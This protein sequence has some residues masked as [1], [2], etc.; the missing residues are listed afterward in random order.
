MKKKRGVIVLALTMIITAFLCY[1]AAV[2]L[3]PTGTGSAKNIHTG[4]DLSGGVSIT[5]QAK[6]KNP[7]KEEMSDTVYKMQKRVEQY[8]TEAQAYQE[9]DNRITVEIPGVTDAD[10]IL[11]DLGKPGSLCFIEQTDKDG[12]EN[13][14]PGEDNYVLARSLEEIREAGSVVLEG[15]DVADAQGGAYQK[16]DGSSR[17]YVVSLKLTDEGKKKFAEAT[18]ANVGKQI[19]IIYDNS[20]LSAPTV[21]EAITGG[22]AEINGMEDVEEAQN[23]A[24]YIRIGSLSLELEEL[25]SSVVAAQL[26]E[27]AISTSVT[28]G[29]IGLAIVILFMIFVYR[30][31]GLVAAIALILYTAITLITLNAFDI[32]LT[33]PGI[34]GIILGIGMAVDA[35]VIIY[36]RIQEEIAEGSSV[37]TAIKSG[38]SKAFSAIVDGN[39]TTLIASGVLMGLGSGT[40][41][42]FA[43]TL[44]LGIVVSMFT[45]LV[46]SRLVMNAMYA[47][48]IQ[49]EKFY[50]RAKKRKSINF[51]GKKSIFF[52]ISLVLIL[53]GPVSMMIHQK[54]DGSI[55]NYSLEFSG[56]TATTVTFNE[57]MDIKKIDSEVTPVVEK[58]TG[59]K[60][61]QPTKVVGTNQVVIKT[62]ALSQDEREALNTA[63]VEKFDVD[64]TLIT[65][66]SISS[67]VSSEMRQDAFVAV[68]V[69]TLCMLAY[70]W[71]RFKDI[72]F[73][74]SAVLALVHDVLVVFA[75]YALARV[76]V[77]N[78]FIACM[79]TIVGY[80]INATIVIFD[81]IREN[82]K[83]KG[84]R[85]DLTEIVNESIT[86]TLTRSIY[87]SLTTFVMVA[88]LFIM[89]VSSI[90]EF[91]LPLMAGIICGAYSSVCITGAL[92]LVMK[93]GF[94]KKQAAI[95]Q[96]TAAEEKATSPEAVSRIVNGQKQPKK[97]NRKRVAERIAREEA[98][99]NSSS[100]QE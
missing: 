49:D 5:Y 24:S 70:I 93:Q 14:V 76:S 28:A 31:P 30:I 52:I 36:A 50:G 86:Q 9:G 77:G 80:S 65:S 38:F 10:K 96:Q 1:T 16:E 61:V 95:V 54:T 73:A 4:L 15:T 91:A 26:G 37:R 71:L 19:A 6:E 48:G 79:L 74:G 18:E 78:T 34:A 67:T 29:A 35:N 2:G 20:V 33:L 75:F 68:L 87:T 90:R 53:V 21:Q 97:K 82:L 40:V 25:R 63:M 94:G 92:W 44:A 47:V 99:K 60:N 64:E 27:E 42:G 41:K 17:E 89:G 100:G 66:E 57:N 88:A 56:G 55:L 46:V 43:Y 51:V 98:E 72:R 11:N 32:T 45:A 22:Q 7:G 39:V 85:A 69:A 3:G 81:R 84:S 8:S 59:D 23:L 83:R 58:V 12:N 13:F 62:R